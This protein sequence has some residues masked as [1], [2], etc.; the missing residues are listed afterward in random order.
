MNRLAWVIVVAVLAFP[1][2]ADAETPA[3]V[4]RPPNIILILADDLGIGDLACL[5]SR[6]IQTPEID[7]LFSRGARLARH[8]SGSASCAASRCVLMQF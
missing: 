3:T 6:D 2:T 8:W 1:T 5:G 7:S 4:R